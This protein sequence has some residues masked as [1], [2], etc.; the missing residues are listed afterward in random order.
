M[1]TPPIAASLLLCL[2]LAKVSAATSLRFGADRLPYLADTATLIVVTAWAEPLGQRGST[3]LS[4][5]ELGVESILLADGGAP[6][7]D[8]DDLWVAVPITGDVESEE[9]FRGAVVFLGPPMDDGDRGYWACDGCPPAREIVSGRHG[10]RPSTEASF[11]ASYLEART[12]PERLDWLSAALR[13]TN[14][15]FQ[16]SA[17]IGMTR[18]ELA[19]GAVR[20]PI[21][22]LVR[23]EDSSMATR[24]LGVEKL[25]EPPIAAPF[26]TSL[27]QD[28]AAPL[29]LRFKALESLEQRLGFDP[30]LKRKL[31]DEPDDAEIQRLLGHRL[32]HRR[33]DFQE[34]RE[35]AP[36]LPRLE[37]HAEAFADVEGED[38][39][40]DLFE[41]SCGGPLERGE[42]FP[43]H[44]VEG[45]IR[46][47]IRQRS[48]DGARTLAW[49]VDS[50]ECRLETRLFALTALTA[51]PPPTQLEIVDTIE[52]EGAPAVLAD[53]LR[54]IRSSARR[55]VTFW[56]ANTDQ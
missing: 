25:G 9:E 35:E 39:Q 50:G 46:E 12:V 40:P 23:D 4:F 22:E 42:G 34:D 24:L 48:L 14:R 13:S 37:L 47:L 54:D 21:L 15:F 41:D 30:D 11:V 36:D 27:A 8:L 5:Y 32:Q 17:L 51:W 28:S 7:P 2:A 33:L 6:P 16:E 44:L 53:L 43:D 55:F 10:V 45:W 38:H 18:P 1:R 26:L 29:T 56:Q 20:S 3:L 19:T 31:I 49:I 52:A